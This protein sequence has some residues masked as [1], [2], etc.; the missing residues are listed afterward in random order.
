M[1]YRNKGIG[2]NFFQRFY[3]FRQRPATLLALSEKNLVSVASSVHYDV[4]MYYVLLYK[5]YMLLDKDQIAL[6]WFS[7]E[8]TL[9]LN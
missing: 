3:I 6:L 2:E 8:V 7:N 1:L 5:N 4:S 9:F